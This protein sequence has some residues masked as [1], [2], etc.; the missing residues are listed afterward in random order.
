MKFFLKNVLLH[1]LRQKKKKLAE[2][3]LKQPYTHDEINKI[4]SEF[5][6]KK[7]ISSEFGEAVSIIRDDIDKSINGNKDDRK[8]LR[9]KI[10]LKMID[11]LRSLLQLLQMKNPQIYNSTYDAIK[12]EISTT[13][14]T[15]YDSAKILF[16]DLRR[17]ARDEDIRKKIE[18]NFNTYQM[19]KLQNELRAVETEVNFDEYKDTQN[20][21]E[22]M[23][24]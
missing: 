10:G 15:K 23:F 22:S 11:N 7:K 18:K 13:T 19:G 4:L 5:R 9:E 3:L 6:G 14:K 20:K 12:K 2:T 8:K 1:I 16:E 21:L 17:G 24:T